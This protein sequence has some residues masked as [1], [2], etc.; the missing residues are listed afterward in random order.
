ME[1]IKFVV[2]LIAAVT[3]VRGTA[4]AQPT[5]LPNTRLTDGPASHAQASADSVQPAAHEMLLQPA[6]VANSTLV[7]ALDGEPLPPGIPIH[8]DALSLESLLQLALTSNPVLAQADAH[9]QALR[10][11]WV[12]VGLPPNPSVGYVAAEMGDDGRAGQQGGFVGQE[13]ITGGKLRL[14]RAVLSQEVNQAEQRLAA[15][16]LRVETDVRKAFYAALVAQRRI[17]LAEELLRAGSQATEASQEL[18]RAE[19]IPQAGLL[20][21]QIEQQN[22]AILVQTAK[23]ELNAAWRQ[24]TAVVGTALDPRPLVG[25]VSQLPALLEWDEQL[26]RVTTTSPEMSTAFAAIQRAEAALDRARVEPVPDISTQASVQY[27]NATGNTIAGVQVGL[28]LPL[29]NRNQGGIRQ[30]Q[31]ELAEARRNAQ[32][33]ELD[34]QRRL[35]VAYQQYANAR[36]QAEVYTTQIL[37][38]SQQTYE[39]VQRGYRLG[40]LGYLD[41]LTAQRTY[42]QTNLFYLDALSALWASSN[43]I[44][45]L[46]LSESLSQTPE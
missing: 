46:L 6:G 20:Q 4:H 19:E 18:L 24:L 31:A 15:I 41:L 11:Q 9:V 10:G 40:E 21:T 25:D 28:P 26:I 39:L 7:P 44:E 33:V 43:E 32:R 14:N 8:S 42:A 34:L 38:K 3:V 13:F 22:F 2:F 35:A 12:Q 37:P 23:N 30:A 17:E 29:W 5:R 45:G 16:R 1:R 27:D 36:T